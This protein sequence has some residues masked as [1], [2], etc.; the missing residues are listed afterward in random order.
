[1]GNKQTTIQVE[2]GLSKSQIRDLIELEKPSIKCLIDSCH[3]KKKDR[4]DNLYE[5]MD[6]TRICD[7][8][9]SMKQRL[10][11]LYDYV[12]KIISDSS[13]S[14]DDIAVQ[15]TPLAKFSFIPILLGPIQ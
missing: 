4:S 15:A 10:G 14:R 5:M 9:K 3:K 2:F 13:R 6:I 8:T 11:C 1:M 7:S 12:D